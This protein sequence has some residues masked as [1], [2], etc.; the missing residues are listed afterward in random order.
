MAYVAVG[1]GAVLGAN[2]RY[3]ISSWAAARW[4]GGFP[5]GTFAVNVSGAFV[6]GLFLAAI[7][8]RSGLSPLVRLFFVTGFLGGY[9]TFSSYAWE[10][11]ALGT[12]GAW[13]RFAL[14]VIG[15]NMMGLTGVW[16]GAKLGTALA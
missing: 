11:L 16:L 12:D 9:T 10:A 7:A 13:A 8:A 5:Y 6:I 15:S 3:A 2:L 14:Y 4:G 1:L